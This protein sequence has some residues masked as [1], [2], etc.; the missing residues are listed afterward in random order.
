MLCWPGGLEPG[1]PTLHIDPRRFNPTAWRWWDFINVGIKCYRLI[2]KT[3]LDIEVVGV[4][5]KGLLECHEWDDCDRYR[6]YEERKD[7]YLGNGE[8]LKSKSVEYR[9]KLIFSFNP[10]FIFI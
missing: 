2:R 6:Y 7:E 8:I 5:Q 3:T 1:Y 9:V 10:P 4:Y